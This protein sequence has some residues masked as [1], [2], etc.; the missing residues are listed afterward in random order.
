MKIITTNE[1]ETSLKILIPM[2][3][4][5]YI[6]GHTEVSAD[7]R[8][9]P[10][11]PIRKMISNWRSRTH[12]YTTMQAVDGSE[13]VYGIPL[14]LDFE[15]ADDRWK[16]RGKLDYKKIKSF[17]DEQYPTLGLYLC[18]YTRSTRG[19]GLGIILFCDP[20][21]KNEKSYGVQFL[22][23]RVQRLLVEVLNFH[24]MGCDKNASG[25]SRFTP[26]WRN[27]KIILR[28][29]DLTIR[30]VQRDNERHQVLTRVYNELRRSPAYKVQTKKEAVCAGKRFA[31][32]TLADN[33]LGRIYSHILDSEP[34]S[35]SITASYEELALISGLSLPTLRSQLRAAAW[36]DISRVYGEGV[37]LILKPTGELSERAYYER[38][39]ANHSNRTDVSEAEEWTLPA[40]ECVGDGER[41]NYLWRRAVLLRNE[42]HSLEETISIIGG[43]SSRIPGAN[44]SRNCRKVQ[45]IVCS[46]FRHERRTEKPKRKIF[47][48]EALTK[49]QSYVSTAAKPQSNQHATEEHHKEVLVPEAQSYWPHLAKLSSDADDTRDEGKTGQI[50]QH[51]V[52]VSSDLKEVSPNPKQGG[53]GDLPPA[54]FETSLPA[55]CIEDLAIQWA[56]GLLPRGI[57][58]KGSKKE[59][60]DVVIEMEAFEMGAEIN[61]PEVAQSKTYRSLR[62]A[63]GA[64]CKNHHPFIR[65]ERTIA[66]LDGRATEAEILQVLRAEHARLSLTKDR[67]LKYGAPEGKFKRMCEAWSFVC[68]VFRREF[69]LDLSSDE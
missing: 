61:E 39:Q 53:E 11:I 15:D 65:L 63:R 30:R 36:V 31:V 67:C 8:K 4:R 50:G 26:N 14:D 38:R 18:T 27:R 46:I 34:E 54:V 40:P 52:M 33:G 22:A 44:Q 45:T 60:T 47:S 21:L 13:M 9:S 17:I 24:G 51:L 25:I 62:E 2:T 19:K 56:K 20:F 41:N 49:S 57:L 66:R 1:G 5:W 6:Y 58:G 35:L 12:I 7:G 59:L 10:I 32:K 68:T 37:R 55:S 16:S 43:E 69:L 28:K 64:S 42:G 3:N 48:L 23:A 29:D